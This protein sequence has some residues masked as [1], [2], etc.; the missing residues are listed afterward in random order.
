MPGSVP[1]QQPVYTSDLNRFHLW[2]KSFSLHYQ[3]V[4]CQRVI[5]QTQLQNPSTG[6]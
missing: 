2:H 6:L 1:S 4:L 5:Q 3:F